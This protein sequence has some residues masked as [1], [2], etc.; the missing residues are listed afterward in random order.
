VTHARVDIYPDGG[1][2][3]VRLHGELTEDGE[4]DLVSRWQALS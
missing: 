2:A 4:R 1:L 3:R